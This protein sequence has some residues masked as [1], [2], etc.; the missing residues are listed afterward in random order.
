MNGS[1]QC[2]NPIDIKSK[3]EKVYK[4]DIHGEFKMYPEKFEHLSTGLF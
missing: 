3:G 1:G 4:K 2:N